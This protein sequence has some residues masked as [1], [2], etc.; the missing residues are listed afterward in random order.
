MDQTKQ[1]ITLTE[2]ISLEPVKDKYV[3]V[4]LNRVESLRDKHNRCGDKPLAENI[5]KRVTMKCLP[6]SV[7]KPIA[8]ALG[9]AQ[10]F[11][12]L[13]RFVIRQMHIAVIGMMDGHAQQP[14]YSAQDEKN[15][16]EESKT[17]ATDEKTRPEAE[18]NGESNAATKGKSKG[19]GKGYGACWHCGEWG[20]PRR[21]CPELNGQKG[22][23]NAL[24]QGFE[25]IDPR[26][27]LW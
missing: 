1:D 16:T 19:K 22:I 17:Q 9:E 13:R 12:Q 27:L 15:L 18:D 7:V 4:L 2:F 3:R 21:E 10:T 25:F 11:R 8:I 14:I 6:Q 23:V 5:I 20:H 24:M 26:W